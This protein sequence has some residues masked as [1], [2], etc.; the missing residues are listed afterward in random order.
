STALTR[1][2]TFTLNTSGGSGCAPMLGRYSR[3]PRIKADRSWLGNTP[4]GLF[5]FAGSVT[6]KSGLGQK[7][8]DWAGGTVLQKL[9]GLTRLALKPESGIGARVILVIGGLE[10]P[11]GKAW[12]TPRFPRSRASPL[13]SKVGSLKSGLSSAKMSVT[14]T[15][16]SEMFPVPLSEI[17]IAVGLPP[18]C[19][20]PSRV[21][22]SGLLVTTMD[23][24]PAVWLAT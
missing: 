18:T 22:L 2:C 14:K 5:V 7:M 11:A 8:L 16:S 19:T 20:I 3:L 17:A 10:L 12:R 4:C 21:G 9:L 15:M 1:A 13:P 24:V 23:T 6:G